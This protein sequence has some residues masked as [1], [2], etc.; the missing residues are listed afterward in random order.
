[1]AVGRR[2]RHGAA[3]CLAMHLTGMLAY[4][5]PI[6]VELPFAHAG[7]LLAGGRIRQP[8][9]CVRGQPGT[10]TSARLAGGSLAVGPASR[11]CSSPPWLRCDWPRCPEY[12]SG[13]VAGVHRSGHFDFPRR[14]PAGLSLARRESRLDGQA[15]HR[16]GH[17]A[18]DSLV[19]SMSMSAG[20]LYAHRHRAPSRGLHRI[21]AVAAAATVGA[22]F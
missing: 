7:R 6:A 18:G 4:R 10:L 3:G 17:R 8:G 12:R 16:A 19:H 22:A 14:P 1:M 9:D 20:E 21:Q 13:A 5:L 15:G 2:D 11:R